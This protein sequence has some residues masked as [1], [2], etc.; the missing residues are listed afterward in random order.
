MPIFAGGRSYTVPSGGQSVSQIA[1][2]NGLPSDMLA[3]HMNKDPDYSLEAGEVV[4][5]P[6]RGYK[7]S[8]AWFF[9]DQEVF[10]S[11]LI[12]GYLMEE[13]PPELFQ[14]VY[15]TPWGKVYK[16]VK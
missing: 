5:I 6:A 15:S 11:V 14:K 7:K 3:Q 13:L 8:Q 12:Q 1:V 16:I 9:M 2:S 10:D 4:E